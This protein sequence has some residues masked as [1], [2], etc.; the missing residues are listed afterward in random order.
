MSV[1]DKIKTS[2]ENSSWIRKM[3]EEG[4]RLKAEAGEENVFDFSLGN[5]D[6]EPP[7]DFFNTL[8]DLAVEN[9]PGIH[10]YMP[11]A[12][13]PEVRTKIAKKVSS[14]HGISLNS[15]SIIMTCG[16]AGGLNIIFKA[17]LNPGDQVIVP[18]P[19]FVEYGFYID[20]HGG[21]M[22]LAET[23][24][25]F[26]L[27][28][29]NIRNAITSKTKAVLINSP[30]N[31]TGKIYRS[32]EIDALSNTLRKYSNGEIFLISD[33]PYREIIYDGIKVPSILISYRHSIVVTSYSKTLS[34]PGERIGYVAVNPECKDF[35]TVMGGLIF[36]NRILGFVNA[37]ALMQRAI[38]A[39]T[40]STVDRETYRGRRDVL[41]EGL[42]MAGY[43]FNKPDGAF[44]IFV[45]SPVPDDIRFVNHLLKY[46][47]LA[48]PGTGFGKSGYFRLAFC[49]PDHVIKKSIP[50]FKEAMGS[51]Q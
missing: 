28:I 32:E 18:T 33:E 14:E 9:T 50:K 24:D 42:S 47:I 12:G 25:D 8:K 17:L 48:V 21:E 4:A 38:A 39:L 44:Y 15:E 10:G 2:I 41:S 7:K 35:N 20:N 31:P 11:N 23:N 43:K 46:N 1:S 51:L 36:S 13:F 40:E 29:N 45:K 19:C 49:V 30:N 3:F 16:A 6:I 22:V 34:I 26:S 37:P 5:P 27:N